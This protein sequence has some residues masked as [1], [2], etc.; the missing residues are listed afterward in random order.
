MGLVEIEVLGLKALPKF[1]ED[2][3]ILQALASNR[4]HARNGRHIE[5]A[6]LMGHLLL[7]QVDRQPIVDHLMRD[8]DRPKRFV[9]KENA[10]H[11]MIAHKFQMPNKPRVLLMVH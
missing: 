8:V 1:S 10:L 3:L 9:L 5:M 11:Q 2:I 7:M 4:R 6:I